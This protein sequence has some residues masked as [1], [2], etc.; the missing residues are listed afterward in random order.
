MIRKADKCWNIYLAC[1]LPVI[2]RKDSK[3]LKK[4]GNKDDVFKEKLSIISVKEIFRTAKD[5]KAG[6][7]GYGVH[8][9]NYSLKTAICTLG[10]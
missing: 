7:L 5:R 1:N 8:N 6:A 2:C 9:R 10:R 3:E 4:A